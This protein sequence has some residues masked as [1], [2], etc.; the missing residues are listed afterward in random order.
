[1]VLSSPKRWV[2]GSTPVEGASQT[3]GS[4]LGP[5]RLFVNT[6]YPILGNLLLIL[7]VGY[8]CLG[9]DT[10]AAVIDGQVAAVHDGER[11]TLRLADGRRR[12]IRLLGIRVSTDNRRMAGIARRHLQT[13]LAGRYVSIDYRALL[14]SGVI[15]GRVLHGGSDIALRMIQA[16]LAEVADKRRLEPA[17]LE[18]YLASETLARSKG[19]GFWQTSR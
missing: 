6:P 11:I 2:T 7:F 14:P 19:M 4:S 17:L 15:L 12:Q 5:V 3:E 9:A 8:A 18:R 10:P 16:G 1:M 13:L